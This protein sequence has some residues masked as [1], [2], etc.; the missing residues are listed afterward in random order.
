MAMQHTE[1]GLRELGDDDLAKIIGGVREA[2]NRRHPDLNDISFP[3]VEKQTVETPEVRSQP[4]NLSGDLLIFP[5][6]Q[7]PQEVS[8]VLQRAKKR[9]LTFFEPY[10][11]SG[12]TLDKDSNVVGWDK[13]PKNWYWNQIKNGKISRDASKLPDS[14]VL[15][16]KTQKPDYKD[17]KQ[18]YQKDPLGSIID[19]LREKGKIQKVKGIP[20]ASRFGV[21]YYELTQVVLPEIA[22]L[23]GVESSAVRLPKAIEFSVI[24]NFK[25]SEWGET[26]TWEWFADKFGD[27]FHLVGGYSGFGGL[28][29]VSDYWSDGNSGHVGFRPLVVVSPKD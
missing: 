6:T 12:V 9:G 5:E 18:M 19:N 4:Q 8:E 26:N 27:D 2:F 23:L 14:W 25:H 16:D 3:S 13:K 11:L 20:E 28:A 7:I 29:Y 15:I 17:G 21:S 24:G 22:S 10:Y 1:G